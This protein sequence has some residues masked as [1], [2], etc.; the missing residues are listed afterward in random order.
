MGFEGLALQGRLME[1]ALQLQHDESLD[2]RVACSAAGWLHVELLSG[3]R[4]RAEMLIDMCWLLYDTAGGELL[5]HHAVAMGLHE[6]VSVGLPLDSNTVPA[7]SVS[8]T[9]ASSST[10]SGGSG[11]GV[12]GK[13]FGP[14]AAERLGVCRE[15]AARLLTC[16]ASKHSHMVLHSTDQQAVQRGVQHAEQLY[17]LLHPSVRRVLLSDT[18]EPT[19]RQALLESCSML[20]QVSAGSIAHWV[21]SGV[22]QAAVSIK[23]EAPIVPVPSLCLACA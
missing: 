4:W 16:I 1:L 13:L 22:L 3:G 23:G 12:Q 18:A 11:S 14:P 8:S 2:E 5:A 9:G 10:S 20:A 17:D 7:G 21:N 19:V 6:L 15:A